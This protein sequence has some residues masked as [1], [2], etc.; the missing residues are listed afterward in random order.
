LT[1]TNAG[2]TATTALLTSFD[3]PASGQ[4]AITADTCTNT[5][6]A[7]ATTCKVSVK[8]VPTTS[9]GA[10]A[11]LLVS[12]STASFASVALSGN[13]LA[14]ATFSSNIDH[15]ELGSVPTSAQSEPYTFVVTN[16]GG[17]NSGTPAISFTGTDVTQFAVASTSCSVALAPRQSCLVA[18]RFQPTTTGAKTA[19]LSVTATPGGTIAFPLTGT[20]IGNGQLVFLPHAFAFAPI[21]LGEPSTA[22]T[23]ELFNA[24]G[25]TTT[26]ITLTSSTP[27][28]VLS[29]NTCTT[30]AS[31]TACT[32]TA[33]W[34]PTTT[35]LHDATITAS[36]ATGGTATVSLP[37][38]ARPRLELIAI[39][40]AAP[41]ATP[42]TPFT[43]RDRVVGRTIAPPLWSVWTVR[44]NT[45]AMQTLSAVQ[46][47]NTIFVPSGTLCDVT[48]MIVAGGTC[49]FGIAFVPA[50]AGLVTGTQSFTIGAGATETVSQAIAGTGTDP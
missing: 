50:T 40:D 37:I 31:G 48:G 25:V 29:A 2:T 14:P 18:V 8:Y 27:E 43:Y 20:G 19:S 16:T 39:D 10:T 7:P 15:H 21:T 34:S 28:L 38:V 41:P 49:S 1:F 9:G 12:A 11:S 36:A 35:G 47:Q 26:D 32:V 4:F 45:S 44:N 23:I 42:M 6:L 46:A 22:Q 30:L 13:G 17:Q 5:T 24:G 33:T 3:G